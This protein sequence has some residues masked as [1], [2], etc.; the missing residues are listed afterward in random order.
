MTK[1]ERFNY[2]LKK[3]MTQPMPV[4]S[5]KEVMDKFG[6]DKEQLAKVLGI[7]NGTKEAATFCA[8][9]GFQLNEMDG[10][11]K[12]FARVLLL[13]VKG[14]MKG[15]SLDEILLKPDDECLG[16]KNWVYECDC[17]VLDKLDEIIKSIE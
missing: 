2:L 1:K 14:E 16:C 8:L 7:Y 4:N 6:K 17:H 13:A 12:M 3:A 15:L 10:L 11:I 9:C 5:V